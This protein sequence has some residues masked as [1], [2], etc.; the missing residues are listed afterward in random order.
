MAT[1]EGRDGLWDANQEAVREIG[2]H[3]IAYD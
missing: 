3:N 1:E 2:W